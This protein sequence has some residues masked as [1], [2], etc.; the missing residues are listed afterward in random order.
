MTE[1]APQQTAVAPPS[2][3]SAP[4]TVE[5]KAPDVAGPAAPS[6]RT[7]LSAHVTV[8]LCGVV[9]V[10]F[11]IWA[12]IST[13]DIVSMATGEV[14]PSTQV[15]TIQHLEG[16]I[17][18]EVLVREGETIREGQLLMKLEPTASDADV[19]ELRVRLRALRIDQARL[20]AL[21]SGAAQPTFPADLASS[22]PEL[23]SQ[24]KT[25]FNV[26]R[27]RHVGEVLRQ[28]QA[29]AQRK[30]EIT[31]IL[32]RIGSAQ[33]SLKLVDEQIGISNE[34]MK[35]NL[36]N[37]FQ[38][39]DLLKEARNLRGSIETNRASLERAK[40]AL[41]EAQ[42]ELE[43]I[44]N[45]LDD[46]NQ[47]ALD[48]ARLTFAELNARVRKFEASLKRTNVTSPI[49]G[50]IKTMHVFTVGGVLRPGDPIADIVPAGDRLIVEAKLPTQ[51]IGYVA[52]GQR[53]V[54]KLASA[55]AMR[56]GGLEGNVVN[57]SPDTLLSPEGQ[58]FYK[59]RIETEKGYFERGAIRYNLFP[60][61]Q[62][63][64][65]IHTGQ[66]TVLQYVIDPIR[67]SMGSAA[68]E[69]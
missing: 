47:T 7:S 46:E 40:L 33:Q 34:L 45:A 10:A 21:A 53:T 56:F 35:D 39:L 31:E 65:S 55:D 60:G 19:A 15:K 32:T 28:E 54:V 50:A 42:A 48:E 36:T 43:N 68:Q 25:R 29:I 14:I 59:V 67:Y 24:A 4:D 23:V 37:R 52:A 66:R 6:E 22:H 69:R 13:L 11:G 62:V 5:H 27:R 58:P 12:S 57:V 16:G 3:V 38:H 30:Q 8:G 49:A 20:E 18:R 63:M 26:R 17:V 41:G 9:V 1:R 51:D 44:Q 64:A 61:M 2:E